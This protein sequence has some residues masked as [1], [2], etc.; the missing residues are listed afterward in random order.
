MFPT[1]TFSSQYST[2][3]PPTLIFDFQVKDLFQEKNK[4]Y[5]TYMNITWKII[6]FNKTKL[7]LFRR[8]KTVPFWYV[9]NKAIHLSQC[10]S[11]IQ[12]VKHQNYRCAESKEFLKYTLVNL[13]LIFQVHA[14]TL[15]SQTHLYDFDHKSIY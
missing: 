6:C 9:L 1:E 15:L 13:L 14:N 4:K 11:N 2:T 12:S 5:G 7:T 10:E 3:P 8:I